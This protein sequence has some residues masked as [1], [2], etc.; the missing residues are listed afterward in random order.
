MCEMHY[1]FWPIFVLCTVLM[2]GNVACTACRTVLASAADVA[3]SAGS[4]RASSGAGPKEEK[5]EGPQ[6]TALDYNISSVLMI[7]MFMSKL[8]ADGNVHRGFA[9]VNI[10]GVKGGRKVWAS[11]FF[12]ASHLTEWD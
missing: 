4:S 10:G 6:V 2:R 5:A 11:F 8:H 7:A 3:A 9:W 12:L 1:T